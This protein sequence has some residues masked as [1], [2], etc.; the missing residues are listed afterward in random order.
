MRALPLSPFAYIMARAMTEHP[1]PIKYPRRRLARGA[2]RF[3][4]PLILPLFFK[5]KVSG[6][7][8]F[9]SGGPLLAVGNHTAVMEAVLM[10]VY[11]PWQV[12]TL[13]AADIPHE[14]LSKVTM[15]FFGFIPVK[16][17]HFDRAALRKALAVLEQKGVIGI[18]PEGGIWNAGAMRPQTGVAWLSYRAN[19]PV[20]PI[21]FGDTTGALGAALKL[22]HPKLTMRIGEL[23]PP[24]RL[25]PGKARKASLE[26][27]A[28]RVLDAIRAL[29]PANERAS[30]S[31]IANERFDLEIAA[32]RPDGRTFPTPHHLSIRYPQA[33]AKMLHR[34]AILKIFTSN[35]CLPTQP[36]QNLTQAPT[37]ARVATA[38]QSILDY[39]QDQNPYLL[40]YRFGPKEAE[41]MALGLEDLLALARWAEQAQASLTITPIRRYE[42]LTQQKEIVQTEQGAFKQWR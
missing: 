42:D 28:Q 1:Y 6:R 35:L 36:L 40:T 16:R 2:A 34:P 30:Q 8:H 11:T 13:G 4:G 18:F 17:G 3:L 24:A 41:Q 38:I 7:E 10:A 9:P 20:L 32:Y 21:G 15:E 22:E 39:L 12:E 33:L 14:T 37:P 26:A 5:I 19:A 29:L 23:L 27:Y 31:T 25:Q